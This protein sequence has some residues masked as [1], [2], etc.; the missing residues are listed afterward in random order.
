MSADEP[1]GPRFDRRVLLRAAGGVAAGVVASTYFDWA[2]Q[3]APA[4]PD[5]QNAEA[6]TPPVLTG[7]VNAGTFISTGNPVVTSIYTADPDAF[8]YNGRFYLDTDRDQAALG[9]GNFV[10][11][12]WHLY[13]T[14]DMKHWTD[15]GAR[16]SLSDIPW[17]NANAWAPQMVRRDGKFYWY[18]PVQQ[19]STGGMTI[20]VLVG[21][22]PLG[23]FTDPLGHPLIDASVANHS[24]FDIDPTV[25]VDDDGQAYLYWGSFSSPR[26]AKL[27]SNMIELAD[28]GG[29]A[30]GGGAIGPRATGRIGNAV[31]LAGTSDYVNLPAGIV[32]DLTDFTIATWVNP[33]AL[34][35]WTRIFDFGTG[36][37]V[38]MFLT[39]NAGAGPRFAITTGGNGREQQLSAT[40]PLPVN[41]WSHVAVTLTGNTGT[42][43]VNG[44]PVATNTNV[45]LRPSNLG[46]TNHNWIGR[47]QFSDPFLNATIDDFQIYR[48]GLTAAE[49][50][51]L[52]GG[53]AGAGDVA[54]YKFDEASGA[55]A[56]DSS[57]SGHDATIVS[58]IVNVLTPQGLTGY[59]EAPWLFKRGGL[60]YL[61]YAR[62]NPATGGNPASIDYAT[63]TAPLGPWTY[64][65][66]V[67]DTVTN[68]TT[69]HSAILEFNGQW[70][71]V[72]HNGA[73]PGGGEFRRSVCIDKL[74]FNDDGTIQKVV[75]TLG[76]A[77]LAPVAWYRLDETSGTAVADATGN[78]WDA[79]LAGGADRARGV[80][81]NALRLNGQAQYASM[82]TGILWNMYDFTI[83]CWVKLN[84]V[85][86]SPHIF[87]FGTGTTVNMY[88]TPSGA[89]GTVRF[90]I[91]TGGVSREQHVDG[92]APLPAGEWAHVAVTKSALT[93]RLYVNGVQVGQN[94]NLSLYPAPL[95]N[96]PNNWIGRSQN[97]ADPALNGLVDDFR[98]YQ[99]GLGPAELTGLIVEGQVAGLLDYVAGQPYGAGATNALTVVLTRALAALRAG[100]P[101]DAL[102]VL[103]NDFTA[104]VA[105]LRGNQVTDPQAVDLLG[106]AAA[107]GTNIRTSMS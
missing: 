7:P 103:D 91:T 21:D 55:T 62:G 3:A 90:A 51:A 106:R 100:R 50:Q 28:L 27:K 57:G 98:V 66:R 37:G 102:G 67:L 29:P 47:S 14:A 65:G 63:A 41:T 26:A 81:G 6:S 9:A 44:N 52:A 12:E 54:C 16:L 89:T 56:V 99:R 92:T 59:W 80:L 38:Y 20:G 49:V 4:A 75:Q 69:N 78:G 95:G 77:A 101:A 107:I 24:S 13:S 87:D 8:V 93:A 40:S 42:L 5:A 72:Y 35:T 83:A 68:T 88:L 105:A 25:L 86:G 45:T 39:V 46:T 23:P 104:Q 1:G 74:Y 79:T 34:T 96:T 18:L 31:K 94:T 10:M 73:L 70:Y 97:S 17:A 19:A 71:I 53:Q 30:S 85:A 33:A 43:Y 36:T 22:S 2:A 64:R 60:Y 11:R 76:P 84:P 48:R 15:H 61:A 32:G 82:P 58:P